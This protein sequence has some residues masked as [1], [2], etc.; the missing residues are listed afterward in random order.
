M[1][2]V[3]KLYGKVG[4]KYIPMKLTSDDVDA[5]VSQLAV[6]SKERDDAMAALR[7]AIE[8]REKFDDRRF[9]CYD[10]KSWRK[11]AGLEQ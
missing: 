10:S 8:F 3:G 2:Y 1:N 5:L 11:A 7:E 9:D 6:V 4:R